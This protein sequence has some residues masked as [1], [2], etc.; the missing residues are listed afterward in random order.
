MKILF[1]IDSLGSGGAQ[2][3]FVKIV[4]HV[5]SIF[6]VTVFLYNPNSEFYLNKI[7]SKIKIYKVENRKKKGFSFR[8]LKELKL[9]MDKT[10]VVVSF[11]LTAN[12]Y[13]AIASLFSNHAK[14]I[15]VEK[16]ISNKFENKLIRFLANLAC[17][18]S[19]LIICNSYTQKKYLSS[20]F[21]LKKK[22]F[23][24]WN[25][26]SKIIYK[27][28]TYENF[29]K[30]Y[31]IGVGRISHPKNILKFLEALKIFYQRNKFV[32]KFFWIG[33]L[34]LSSKLSVFMKEQ[35]DLFLIN[36]PKINKNIYFTG[37]QKNLKKFYNN[38]NALVSPSIIEGLSNVICEA[39]FYGCPVLASRISDNEKVLGKNEAR[40]FL[41]NPLSSVDM[42]FALERYYKSSYKDIRKKTKNA[43]LYATNNF[44]E[45]KM[46]SAYLKAIRLVANK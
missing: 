36:N 5:S 19:D 20:I 14:R 38:A 21:G 2:T 26:H 33:R 32:P 46:T 22:L 42:C 7:S 34:D 13:V 12:I 23:V 40:G 45:I 3:Q 18:H 39:M 37:E 28:K 41:F 17:L 43:Y 8:V 9:F 44:S 4:N 30:S 31:F 29:K 11:L 16:S 6:D 10:D 1:V 24:I 27:P 25:G 15:C 35:I